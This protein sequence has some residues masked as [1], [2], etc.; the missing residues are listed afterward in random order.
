MQ[1]KL[2]DEDYLTERLKNMGAK[3]FDIA[4]IRLKHI[5]NFT[6][7]YPFEQIEG[8]SVRYVSKAYELGDP[9][10]IILPGTKNTI[11]DLKEMRKE[12]LAGKVVEKAK[13]GTC[14]FGICG[15]Y[16]MLGRKISDPY[17]MEAGGCE[18]GLELLPVDTVLGKEKVCTSFAGS[19]V[20]ATGILVESA[21]L[22]LEGYEIHM[23]STDP[24]EELKE[25]TSD[26]TGYCRGNVY[27]TYIHGFF[28][29]R[30]ICGS[31]IRSVARARGKEIDTKDVTDY[32]AYKDRQYDILAEELKKSLD[33][34]YIYKI[35]GLKNDKG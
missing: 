4:V 7:L 2:D 6:D 21:D 26:Q 25:F 34:D 9:D 33:I 30:E 14:I 16:Q 18:C 17:D 19:V 10:M 8:V 11:E 28:D 3:G 24:F 23:G 20:G 31:V 29:K 32:A 22:R 5:S 15:G 35:M 1:V 27:G 13:T 12:G